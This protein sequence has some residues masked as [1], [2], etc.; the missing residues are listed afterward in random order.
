M[1]TEEPDL[2]NFLKKAIHSRRFSFFAAL[3]LVTGYLFH[4]GVLL[5]HSTQHSIEQRVE[6]KSSLPSMGESECRFCDNAHLTPEVPQI[7]Q[8]LSVFQLRPEQAELP[9]AELT[10][11]LISYSFSARAPPLS[12]FF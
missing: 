5:V 11:I 7:I 3:V 6:Q 10:W 9:S 2:M 12:F 1:I 8:K 4:S